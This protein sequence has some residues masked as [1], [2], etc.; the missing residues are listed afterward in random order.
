MLLR[1]DSRRYTEPKN[2]LRGARPDVFKF[3]EELVGKFKLNELVFSIRDTKYLAAW[4]MVWLL[5]TKVQ[6][7]TPLY[8][9]VN[10]KFFFQ[11]NSLS[12]TFLESETY[13]NVVSEQAGGKP[14]KSWFFTNAV[15]D[16]YIIFVPVLLL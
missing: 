13:P 6:K 12:N 10:F 1:I 9:F 2:A 4:H 7:F 14:I 5:Q 3:N 16:F 8:N 11:K 15:C